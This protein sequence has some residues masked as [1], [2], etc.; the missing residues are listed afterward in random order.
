MLDKLSDILFDFG[1]N[2]FE[3]AENTDTR[4]TQFSIGKTEVSLH[5]PF[6]FFYLL[7]SI[8][9]GLVSMAAGFV[10]GVIDYWWS[11]FNLWF[12][13][14]FR[15]TTGDKYLFKKRD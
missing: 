7:L 12:Y 8:P 2:L 10:L 14:R 4:I 9:I 1:E 5:N 11:C 13:Q 6:K 3:R 15:M